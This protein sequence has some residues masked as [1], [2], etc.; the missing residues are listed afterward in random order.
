[1]LVLAAGLYER[2]IP[3]SVYTNT[4]FRMESYRNL[5]DTYKLDPDDTGS[6][7]LRKPRRDR[8][9]ATA[10]TDKRQG[11]AELPMI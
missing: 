10:A 9:L 4:V 5:D 11:V 2:C 7:Q 6:E 1:L 8:G 3:V